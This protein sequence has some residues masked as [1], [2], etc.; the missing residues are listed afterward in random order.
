LVENYKNHFREL[1]KEIFDEYILV[2]RRIIVDYALRYHRERKRWGIHL[3][4]RPNL[5]F[6]Q[7][8]F[9]TGGYHRQFHDRWHR[10]FENSKR[11]MTK[12][13]FGVNGLSLALH[14]WFHSFRKSSLTELRLTKSLGHLNRALSPKEFFLFQ[15]YYRKMML[16]FLNQIMIRGAYFLIKKR[17]LF[18]RNDLLKLE[19]SLIG[20][21]KID[22]LV[23]SSKLKQ[24]EIHYLLKKLKKKKDKT[25]Y[26]IVI[27]ILKNLHR[28]DKQVSNQ[29]D[30]RQLMMETKLSNL[31][32]IR[33]DHP[34][35]DLSNTRFAF[36]ENSS[37]DN[38]I[39]IREDFKM[40]ILEGPKTN[41][42]K[43][44]I[45]GQEKLE[46]TLGTLMGLRLRD[47]LAKSIEDILGFFESY[48]EESSHELLGSH[49]NPKMLKRINTETHSP[50]FKVELVVDN[51]VLKLGEI[52]KKLIEELNSF[53]LGLCQ[54]FK[55]VRKPKFINIKYVKNIFEKKVKQLN[56][57]EQAKND[58]KVDTVLGNIDKQ[59]NN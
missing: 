37:W 47:I 32:R 46:K 9:E 10:L 21:G 42:T 48:S 39:Y 5:S 14:Q 11:F 20:C 49:C 50:I 27:E 59:N 16:G 17:R 55:N 28:K 8:I 12:E 41:Q 56:T 23:E 18:C 3:L 25:D 58:V 24:S 54:S 33:M 52:Q 13:F 51:G 1:W 34:Q 57:E 29:E 7:K 30:F 53:F 38:H 19:W 44:E 36:P 6:S 43:E 15:E 26:E 22:P 45:L 31:D 4:K 40:K 2:G 35:V